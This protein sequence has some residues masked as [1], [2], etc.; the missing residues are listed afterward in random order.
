MKNN[1][2][3]ITLG[4]ALVAILGV[5]CKKESATPSENGQLA[6]SGTKAVI[7]VN[8]TA[9]GG[10]TNSA[11]TP[12]ASGWGTVSYDLTNNLVVTSAPEALFNQNFN[13]NISAAPGY[14]LSYVDL[15]S[16]GSVADVTLADLVAAEEIATLGS[17]TATVIGWYNYNSSARTIAPVAARYAVISTNADF[18]VATKVLV[19]QLTSIVGTGTGPYN[20]DVDFTTKRL[21]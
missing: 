1:I 15:P 3:K 7:P 8:G 16:A 12:S 11:T 19:V 5:S 14:V 9:T 2:S 18:A 6:I 17:N 10:F 4:L 21:K 20:T 13:G